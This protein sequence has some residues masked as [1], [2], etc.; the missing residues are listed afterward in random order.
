MLRGGRCRGRY[1]VAHVSAVSFDGFRV[2]PTTR[3]Q[4]HARGHRYEAAGIATVSNGRARDPAVLGRFSSAKGPM[5]ACLWSCTFSFGDNQCQG[6]TA[7]DQT[8]VLQR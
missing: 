4:E 5:K 2:S 1:S 7:G 3:V 6:G 8:G